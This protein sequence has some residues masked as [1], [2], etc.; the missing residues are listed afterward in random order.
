ML[1]FEVVAKGNMVN[2]MLLYR[3][4]THSI[5][6]EHDTDVADCQIAWG[7][8]DPEVRLA[9]VVVVIKYEVMLLCFQ[10]LTPFY[11]QLKEL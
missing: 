9:L 3:D 2:S 1:Q 11:F 5:C 6:I 7:Y 10:N 8:V 4:H